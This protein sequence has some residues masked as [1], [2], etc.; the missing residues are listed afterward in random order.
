MQTKESQVMHEEPR[1]LDQKTGWLQMLSENIDNRFCRITRHG[2]A[3]CEK[4][5]EGTGE[6]LN[7]SYGVR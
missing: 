1:L 4:K 7:V 5:Q 2:A 3:E 6:L